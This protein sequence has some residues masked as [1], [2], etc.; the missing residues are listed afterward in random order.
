MQ[1]GTAHHRGVAG[2]HPEREV[3]AAARS[4]DR[5]RA[6]RQ[7]IDQGRRIIGLLHG[8]RRRPPCRSRTP[9]V[10][11]PVVSDDRELVGQEIG[12][13]VE[14][15]A[16]AGRPHDQKNRRTA[17]ADL[18]VELGTVDADHRHRK[19]RWDLRHAAPRADPRRDSR[20]RHRAL[21]VAAA[22]TRGGAS[23][24]GAVGACRNASRTRSRA[25]QASGMP[26]RLAHESPPSRWPNCSAITCGGTRARS[27]RTSR[28]SGG[29]PCRDRRGRSRLSSARGSSGT[30]VTCREPSGS[31]A[32][33]QPFL[34]D[35]LPRRRVQSAAAVG[36]LRVA[37]YCVVV[38]RH[39][40]IAIVAP[41]G[42]R[43]AGV[44]GRTGGRRLAS[45]RD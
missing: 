24:T 33:L 13:R 37:R 7:R 5:Q 23:G 25:M 9:A 10:P 21:P 15:T 19:A 20:A 3:P 44:R 41:G 18:V 4:E 43:N 22:G 27:T 35:S 36:R 29:S 2:Q 38:T 12:E 42:A 14:M 1:D 34:L 16:V 28:S 45:R 17:A 11:T 32:Q 40:Q 6:D 30:S 8:R 31:A 26:V 39:A